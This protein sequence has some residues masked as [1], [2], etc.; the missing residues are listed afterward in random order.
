MKYSLF[1]I[2]ILLV[3]T[4]AEAEALRNDVQEIIY[5]HN[6]FD[7]SITLDPRYATPERIESIKEVIFSQE[8]LSIDDN[9]MHKGPVGHF[10]DYYLGWELALNQ[11]ETTS[12]TFDV[13]PIMGDI[14]IQLF[15]HKSDFSGRMIPRDGGKSTII[16]YEI[17]TWTPNSLKSILRHELG[18][19]FG[20]GHNSGPEELMH[21]KINGYYPYISSCNIA[22]LSQNN[23]TDFRCEK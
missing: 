18:H 17:E 15:N 20:L 11:V 1:L 4:F 2:P 14:H 12:L 19:S 21:E 7:S 5:N 6:N 16:I 3:L 13:T 22:A 9:I 23:T 8:V 10:T